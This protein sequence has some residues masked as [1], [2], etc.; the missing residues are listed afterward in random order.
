MLN[1]ITAAELVAR[2]RAFYEDCD[3]DLDQYRN[4]DGEVEDYYAYDRHLS[5]IETDAF[6][7][8]GVLLGQLDPDEV[9][10]PAPVSWRHADLG[11]IGA[12]YASKPAGFDFG[13]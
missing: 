2:L 1:R 9:I 10:P 4:E 5:D 6:E 12:W 3:R 7:V 8:I 11:P 13:D